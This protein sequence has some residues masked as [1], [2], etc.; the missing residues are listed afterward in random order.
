MYKDHVLL[1]HMQGNPRNIKRIFNVIS[2]TAS[3]IKSLQSRV[4]YFG[5]QFMEFLKTLATKKSQ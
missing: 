3:V 4:R 5:T 2:I 1:Q